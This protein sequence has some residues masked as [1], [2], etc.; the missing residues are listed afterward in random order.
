MSN[1][2]INYEEYKRI[3]E[4]NGKKC[5]PWESLSIVERMAFEAGAQQVALSLTWSDDDR[6]RQEIVSAKK[7]R[8]AGFF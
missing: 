3:L 1:G 8:N 5:G 2:R 6:K 4:E 7:S